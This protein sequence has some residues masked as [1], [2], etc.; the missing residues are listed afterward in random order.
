MEYKLVAWGKPGE[1]GKQWR[2]DAPKGTVVI[3]QAWNHPQSD[4]EGEVFRVYRAGEFEYEHT[5]LAN[6]KGFI[7]YNIKLGCF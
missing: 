7:K 6:V 4:Y 5:T 2:L 3:Q 1:V